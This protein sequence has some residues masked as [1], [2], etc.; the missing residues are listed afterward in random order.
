MHR[1]EAAMMNILK[2]A[3][4]AIVGQ[5][6]FSFASAQANPSTSS[7]LPQVYQHWLD[8]DVSWIITA[9]ERVAFLRLTSD[10]ERKR[11]VKEFWLRRDP[12]PGTEKN[13]FKEEHYRRI[14]YS[15]VHFAWQALPGWKT[16]RGRI[17]IVFGP[18]DEIRISQPA[19]K[20]SSKRSIVWHYH[21]ATGPDRE[22]KFIDVCGCGDY[23]LEIP[24]G[25]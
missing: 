11:F 23:R 1:W 17:Y 5:L 7:G 2:L 21:S 9:D 6:A 3:A 4:L 18:P 19:D 8:E 16:D 14:A 22:L 12:T 25:N 10:D 24:P 20:D 15:N 13:E